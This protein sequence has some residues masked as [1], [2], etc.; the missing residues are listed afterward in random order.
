MLE[1]SW[2]TRSTSRSRPKTCY[3]DAVKDLP[4]I[5]YIDKSLSVPIDSDDQDYIMR[6]IRSDY[7]YDSTVTV[8]LIGTYGAE[9]RGALEQ[10]YIKKE[11]Q[12]SL[13]NGE[14]HSKSGILGVVLPD[15]KSTVFQGQHNCWQCDGMH[16]TVKVNYSTTIREFSYNY[17]IPHE[18]CAWADEHRYCVLTDWETFKSDPNTWIDSAYD[19]RFARIASKTKVR[20]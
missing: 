14:V 13:Y 19:K 8:L 11:L 12:A 7:L 1:E 2:P 18:K 5:E 6:R 3:K 9:D 4:N 15:M 16:N 10:Y 20:P 17:Y